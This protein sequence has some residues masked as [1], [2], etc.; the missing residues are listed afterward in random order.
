MRWA[1]LLSFAL[2]AVS[3]YGLVA[4]LRGGERGIRG[5]RGLERRTEGSRV[6]PLFSGG[7]V[8]MFPPAVWGWLANKPRSVIW[9]RPPS[10]I[11]WPRTNFSKPSALAANNEKSTP[12]PRRSANIRDGTDYGIPLILTPHPRGIFS[13]PRPLLQRSSLNGGSRSA[14][15]SKLL[16]PRTDLPARNTGGTEIWIS[17]DARTLK[18]AVE[19]NIHGWVSS[20]RKGRH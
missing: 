11:S 20:N 3:C 1:L 19:F 16:P 12:I 15:A 14:R 7:M 10:A 6:D 9:F 8:C 13:T 18:N 5:G 4:P 17:N 2:I